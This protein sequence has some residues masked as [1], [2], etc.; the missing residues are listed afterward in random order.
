MSDDR[1]L[2]DTNIIIFFV[3]EGNS[4]AMRRLLGRSIT[5]SV[6]TRME[7]YAA[8][9]I[10][11]DGTAWVDGFLSHCE[12][13]PLLRAVQDEAVRIRRTYRLEMVDAIIAATAIIKSLPLI[14]ADKAIMA[15]SREHDVRLF[16][17]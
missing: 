3:F 17:R 9:G 1:L 7:L 4:K 12:E 5:V 10:T 11:K 14:T 15:L 16:E 2:V 6:L 8:P 13:V